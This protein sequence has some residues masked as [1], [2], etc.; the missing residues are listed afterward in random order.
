ML[1]A[2]HSNP[3]MN[4]ITLQIGI[5]A[6]NAVETILGRELLP[7]W[8]LFGDTVNTASRMKS[9]GKPGRIHVSERVRQQAMKPIVAAWKRIDPIAVKQWHSLNKHPKRFTDGTGAGSDV[10]LRPIELTKLDASVPEFLG[11]SIDPEL[12]H[13]VKGKGMMHT[14]FVNVRSP[15][16]LLFLPQQPTSMLAILAASNGIT[17][18][19]GT[20]LL[21]PAPSVVEDAA[22]AAS[23]RSLMVD[24]LQRLVLTVDHS[25]ARNLTMIGNGQDALGQPPPIIQSSRS[26][27]VLPS[28]SPALDAGEPEQKHKAALVGL[29]FMRMLSLADSNTVRSTATLQ[30][31]EQSGATAR[32]TGSPDTEGEHPPLQY[33]ASSMS[34]RDTDTL[35][36]RRPTLNMQNS[37]ASFVVPVTEDSQLDS[38]LG[39]AR[40][41]SSQRT[42][43]LDNKNAASSNMP[44]VKSFSV[45][46]ARKV[47]QLVRSSSE[48]AR[49]RTQPQALQQVLGDLGGLSRPRSREWQPQIQA[50]TGQHETSA[51]EPG[52]FANVSDLK[53]HSI[54]PNDPSYDILAGD[55]HKRIRATPEEMSNAIPMPV[56]NSRT[57]FFEKAADSE[58]ERRFLFYLTGAPNHYLR[59]SMAI[60]TC[61]V[62]FVFVHVTTLIRSLFGLLVLSV[63]A[64]VAGGFAL[65]SFLIHL[66]IHPCPLF[67]KMPYMRT[68]LRGT[69]IAQLEDRE[70]AAIIAQHVYG[71]VI[72][73][74]TALH[75]GA[76]VH[77]AVSCQNGGCNSSNS[78]A[79]ESHKVYHHAAFHHIVLMIL[80]ETLRFRF[81]QLSALTTVLLVVASVALAVG[82]SIENVWAGGWILLNSVISLLLVRSNERRRRSDFFL[83]HVSDEG[84]KETL[85]MLYAMLPQAIAKPLLNSVSLDSEQFTTNELLDDDVSFRCCTAGRIGAD[86]LMS[87]RMPVLPINA[88]AEVDAQSSLY[89]PSTQ[90][91]SLLMFDLVGFTKLSAT[92]GPHNLVTMLD[93]LYASFDRIVRKRQAYKVETIGDAFLVSCGAPEVMPP[94][95][96]AVIVAKCAIEM[97]RRVRSFAA[98][99]G[100]LLQARVGIH[101]GRVMAGVI[102]SHMPRYQLFG[103]EVDKVMLLESSGQAGRVHA[104]RAILQHLAA[105]PDL[106]VTETLPDGTGFVDRDRSAAAFSTW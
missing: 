26:S 62:A 24:E 104:S 5:N 86:E 85:N 7:R 80:S 49:H 15:I 40:F 67:D 39:A 18:S 28:V 23:I 14:H 43:Q 42:I 55:L 4:N 10:Q 77:G 97:L 101:V 100:H 44:R 89:E 34:M 92:I 76:L 65:K 60:L 99:G 1:D 64:I 88:S 45:Q 31:S 106:Q 17:E 74:F 8:K 63:V 41:H 9:S 11:F 35:I 53:L 58:L 57:L 13:N 3:E 46:R 22:M 91:V 12:P 33:T 79:D 25:S 90:L 98:P 94:D 105:A 47:S 27:Q 32:S 73:L 56:L 20:W 93:K 66:K 78:A 81:V 87:M 96:S 68:K 70:L 71:I 38:V 2:I 6:G 48:R 21:K 19:N 84:S 16:K 50:Q 36:G 75:Y 103:T 61:S 69:A 30:T 52:N 72:L 83:G 37:S 51:V 102:S 54:R 29:R 82:G 59:G 95:K